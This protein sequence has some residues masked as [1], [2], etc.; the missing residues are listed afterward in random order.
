MIARPMRLLSAA[1]RAFR[2]GREFTA[3]AGAAAI[4]SITPPSFDPRFST[5]LHAIFVR[6]RPKRVMR[7]ARRIE[8]HLGD[9]PEAD[10][11]PESIHHAISY[12]QNRIEIRWGE[13]RGAGL[14]PWTPEV[15]IE[16]LEHLARSLERGKGAIL[17]R[18]SF[19]S[20][21]VVNSGLS[22]SGYDLI[23]LSSTK[24]RHSNDSWWSRKV[25]APFYT[26][27]EARWLHRRVLRGQGLGYLLELRD[28][29][30]RNGVVTIVGDLTS[31]RHTEK[32]KIG[33]S[34]HRI[35]T[36]APSLAHSTG[37][38]LHTCVA[39]RTAPFFYCLTIG[40]DL[41]VSR[42]ESKPEARR[43][44]TAQYA[45]EVD[46][47]LRSNTASSMWWGRR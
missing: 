35:P 19:T 11:S 4:T 6:L 3:T 43:W 10:V 31:A 30:L 2:N 27:S 16:G 37:A 23:H 13:A 38:S 20:A 47:Q 33:N 12:F 1:R 39:I 15:K 17:W 46:R 41:E 34:T 24:H 42:I 25:S 21:T 36:G 40:P 28:E 18:M 22:Q 8:D 44:A 26:R 7:I 45:A 5:G 32:H 9:G 29:L 14:R